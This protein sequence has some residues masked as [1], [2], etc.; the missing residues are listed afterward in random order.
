MLCQKIGRGTSEAAD[1]EAL[2]E[3]M[4][5]ET[6]VTQVFSNTP[7]MHMSDAFLSD[8]H[9]NFIVSR[10]DWY[11]DDHPCSAR[12]NKLLTSNEPAM[13]QLSPDSSATAVSL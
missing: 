10:N 2:S 11:Y 4:P 5:V 1:E 3:V 7:K 6:R 9:H 12:V 13:R 8:K